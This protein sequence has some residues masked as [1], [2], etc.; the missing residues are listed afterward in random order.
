MITK[1]ELKGLLY[2]LN[3]YL[4]GGAVVGVLAATIAVNSGIVLLARTDF[5]FSLSARTVTAIT[6]LLI[7]IVTSL[8]GFIILIPAELKII[9]RELKPKLL[10]QRLSRRNKNNLKRP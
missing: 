8:L 3:F 5:G 6:I 7:G 10:A 9:R 4:L 2:V 1:I